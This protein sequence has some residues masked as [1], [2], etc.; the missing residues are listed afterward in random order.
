MFAFARSSTVDTG[1]IDDCLLVTQLLTDVTSQNG[2]VVVGT[3]KLEPKRW[4]DDLLDRWSSV[5]TWVGLNSSG[6]LPSRTCQ[7]TYMKSYKSVKF[8]NVKG[9]C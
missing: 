8:V 1:A 6:R 7:Y 5:W 3:L 9:F 2:T 4:M